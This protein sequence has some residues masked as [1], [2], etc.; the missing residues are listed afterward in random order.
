MADLLEC[1]LQVKGLRETADRLSA[2]AAEADAQQWTQPPPD[3]GLCAADLLTLL[4]EIEIVHGSWL[5]LMLASPRPLLAAFD[6]R[7]L[8]EVGRRHLWTA[9]Q[10]LDRFF[11]Y[12]RDNLDLL[13]R[14]SAADFS[15]T[16]VHAT[17]REMTVADLVAVMMATDTERVGEIRSALRRGE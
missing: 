9:A 6:A 13:D 17:R 8:L 15:R 3:G 16:A 7:A 5:R 4:V 11:T 1:L 2:L 12:R 14:C 10:A